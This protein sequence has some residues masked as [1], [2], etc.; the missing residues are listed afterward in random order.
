MKAVR[1]GAFLLP[2]IFTSG[3]LFCGFMAVLLASR[4]DALTPRRLLGCALAIIAAALFDALDGAVAR[5]LKAVSRL[6]MEYDSLCDLVSFGVAPAVVMYAWVLHGY[7]RL[8]MLVAFLYVACA[9]LRL[10][11]FNVQVDSVEKKQFQG[12]PSPMSAL[13]IASA[14]LIW[15]EAPVLP[16]HWLVE[17]DLPGALLFLTAVLGGLMVSAIPY[18]ALKALRLHV[19]WPFFAMVYIILGLVVWAMKPSWILFFIASLY[20][21]SGPVEQLLSGRSHIDARTRDRVRRLHL[22]KKSST[23]EGDQH[24]R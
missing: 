9:T 24:Q 6:G 2:S 23:D 4:R 19:R 18:R 15:G 7:G 14:I 21:L 16:A 5:G 20:L 8:G 12:L 1:R 17:G 13:V 22:L 11:R 10:A 3:N